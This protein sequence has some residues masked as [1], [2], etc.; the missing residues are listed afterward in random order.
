MSRIRESMLLFVTRTSMCKQV[1]GAEFDVS[2]RTIAS[3]NSQK[4]TA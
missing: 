1:E 4:G 2:K 3:T